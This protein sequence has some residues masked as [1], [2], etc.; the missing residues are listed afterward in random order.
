VGSRETVEETPTLAGEVEAHH[1]SIPVVD[2][3]LDETALLG[4][5]D[6][7]HRTVVPE[8]QVLG[9][10]TDRGLARALVPSNGEQ[11][12]VL[13]AGEPSR[14]RLLVARC[15]RHRRPRWRG[16]ARSTRGRSG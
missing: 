16:W 14:C 10:V 12:L 3:A 4:A 13:L 11:Q 6:E 1:A 2:D 7:L 9:H 8:Q 5:V 15:G